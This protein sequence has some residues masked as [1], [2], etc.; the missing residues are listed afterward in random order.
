MDDLSKMKDNVNARM[1]IKEY[2]KRKVLWIT[3]EG[4]KTKATYVLSKDKKSIYE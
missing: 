3:T 1:D 2:C 4:K